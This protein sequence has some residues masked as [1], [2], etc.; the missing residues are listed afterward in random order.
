MPLFVRHIKPARVDSQAYGI[1]W[2]AIDKRSKK[3]VAVKK[4]FDAFRN[5]TDAQVSVQ[6]T[7]SLNAQPLKLHLQRTFREIM[8]LSSE[9]R[10][11]PNIVKLV[12]IIRAEND[13]DIYLVFEHLGTGYS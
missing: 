11:H 4:C 13:S 9:M 7:K 5:A 6:C 12:N 2:K 3:V 10:T 8:Y 1:V